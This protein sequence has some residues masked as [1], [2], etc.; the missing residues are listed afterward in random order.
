M[1]RL[2]EWSGGFLAAATAFVQAGYKHYTAY[3]PSPYAYTPKKKS[4]V[5]QLTSVA[6]ALVALKSAE[7]YTQAAVTEPIRSRPAARCGPKK[8]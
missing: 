5:V 2:A 1:L 7:P 3:T 4:D 8:N 6:E